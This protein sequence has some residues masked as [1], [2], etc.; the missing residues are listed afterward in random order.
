MAQQELVLLNSSNWSFS[1]LHTISGWSF[2]WHLLEGEQHLQSEVWTGS[3]ILPGLRRNKYT[4]SG[5]VWRIHT[6]LRRRILGFWL[7]H[8][9]QYGLGH[10]LISMKNLPGLAVRLV[11]LSRIKTWLRWEIRPDHEQQKLLNLPCMLLQRRR[12]Q[13][14]VCS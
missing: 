11:N 10:S 2:L 9:L 7:C 3:N 6:W 4:S 5:P 13:Q 8:D 1:I 12:G 14:A